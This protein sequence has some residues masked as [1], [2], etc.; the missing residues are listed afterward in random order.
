M[1]NVCRIPMTGKDQLLNKRPESPYYKTIVVMIHEWMYSVDVY[2]DNTQKNVGFQEIER[3]IRDIVL[4]AQG[5]LSAGEKAIAVGL[6]SG[7]DRDVWATVS[8]SPRSN[9]CALCLNIV[10]ADF[11]TDNI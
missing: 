3:R 11:R 9:M 6:L 1:F 4:D 8:D 5:R 2:D 10:T 7:D